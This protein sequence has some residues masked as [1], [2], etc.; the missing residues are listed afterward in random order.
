MFI[1]KKFITSGLMGTEG[2]G[3]IIEVGDGV[4]KGL[5]GKKVSYFGQAYSLYKA[6]DL[7]RVIILDDS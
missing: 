1:N 3:I 7:N 6:V 2:S 4:D 5:I